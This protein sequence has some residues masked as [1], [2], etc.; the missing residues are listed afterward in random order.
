MKTTAMNMIVML[1]LAVSGSCKKGGGSSGD[2]TQPTVSINNSMS[3]Q[4]GNSGNTPF[5]FT[6]TLS[7][8]F[9]K[10][11]TIT[12]STL[13]GTA[14]AG[15]DY[16]AV[17]DQS[18]VFQPNET[19][20][21][22]IVNVKGDEIREADEIFT[23]MLTGAT[24]ASI[25]QFNSTATII[26]DDL[27]VSFNNTGYDA[28]TGY[29]GYTLTWADEFNSGALNTSN[30][31]V[32]EG[33]GCPGLC[34]WG[35]NE[36]EYY[37]G[38]PENLFFQ[39]GKMMIEARKENFGGRAYTSSKIVSRNKRVFKYGRVDIRAILPTGRG[40]WPAFWML[41]QHNVFG[42]WPRS[43]EIDIMEMV[44][45]EPNR[46]YGTLHYGPGPGSIHISRG[47]SLPGGASF[48][49]A[50]HVFS[51]EW[52]EDEVKWFIDGNLFSTIQ[53]TDIGSNNWPFNEEFFF[54]I[55]FAVG[56]NW[57]GNPDAATYFPQWLIVDY[58]RVYQ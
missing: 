42:G 9:S 47:Y 28:P 17:T 3:K 34:G 16:T 58:I 37:T 20:K 7:K 57:P 35:N 13:E 25:H 21:T 8:T 15:S 44:G 18:L 10:P 29:P 38:R 50:F 19:E 43:G 4:E 12:W 27:N 1:L 45:H 51:I 49:D 26:N 56:G 14:K 54:I 36:L 41:P 2:T 46:S 52:K 31:T 40:T 6:V 55:N 24:N 23:V 30:W 11:V 48:N 32:E 53:K 33:D 22:I 39:D 5:S